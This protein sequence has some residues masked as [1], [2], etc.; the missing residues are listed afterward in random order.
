[1]TFNKLK[2]SE[3]TAM[4]DLFNKFGHLLPDVEKEYLYKEQ[5]Q[6][7]KHK[8]TFNNINKSQMK[9]H[10]KQQDIELEGFSFYCFDN[11]EAIIKEYDAI[12]EWDADIQWR[13]SEVIINPKLIKLTLTVIADVATGVFT[14]DGYF[15]PHEEVYDEREDTIVI[16]PFS[17]D[18]WTIDFCFDTHGEKSEANS[19][20][21]RDILI[22]FTD[23]KVQIDL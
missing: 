4:Q 20:F 10:I 15:E 6:F 11:E 7:K 14:G 19:F 23:K 2:K 17:P 1:M 3:K 9:A 16:T 18:N 5:E 21:I 22:D 8:L 13:S 12:V